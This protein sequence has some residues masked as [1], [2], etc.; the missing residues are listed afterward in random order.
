MLAV[1]FI[2]SSTCRYSHDGQSFPS[3]NDE[4]TISF[5]VND[6]IFN[7]SVVPACI[8]LVDSNDIPQLFT[9]ANDT[10]D[11]MVMYRE[12]QQEPLYLAPELEIRGNIINILLH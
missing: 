5:V 11:T 4:R 2:I 9:G 1:W 7:S 10:V 8:Q 3:T 6:G 12:G